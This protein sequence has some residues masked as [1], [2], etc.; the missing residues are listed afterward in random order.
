MVRGTPCDV[1]SSSKIV[2]GEGGGPA[3]EKWYNNERRTDNSREVVNR[4]NFLAG[5]EVE[6]AKRNKLK[7]KGRLMIVVD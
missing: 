3:R 4:R 5:R 6:F 7:R 1:R 2:E